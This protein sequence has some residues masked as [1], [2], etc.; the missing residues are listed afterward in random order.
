MNIFI[1]DRNP[2]IAA[3]MHCDEHLNKM[4]LEG[5]QL[6]ST[7]ANALLSKQSSMLYSSTHEN[8][9]CVHWLKE[10]GANC[11]WLALLVEGLE[12]ERQ[13]RFGKRDEHLSMQ[14]AR[15]AMEVVGSLA[16][17]GSLT[18]FAVV[19]PEPVIR[20]NQNGNHSVRELYQRYYWWKSRTQFHMHWSAP[21]EEPEFMKN[22][23]RSEAMS[24][25]A[26]SAI[27]ATQQLQYKV[28]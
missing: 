23:S 3:T 19:I 21:R 18:P 6:L 26:N 1:L 2:R 28:Q 22:L 20:A 5:A 11:N 7:V 25:E 13:L 9:P 4:I 15:Y 8:H 10:S 27:P 16:S 17:N 12:A 14:K 24:Q